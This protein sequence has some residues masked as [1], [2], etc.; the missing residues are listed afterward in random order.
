MG[1]SL[2][3]YMQYIDK[4]RIYTAAMPVREAVEKSVTECIKEGDSR[5]VSIKKQIGGDIYEYIRI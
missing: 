1:K 4:V 2:Y 5:G 3:D